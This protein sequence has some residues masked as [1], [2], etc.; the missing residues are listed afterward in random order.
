MTRGAYS[1]TPNFL[2]NVERV[3][4]LPQELHTSVGETPLI[5]LLL[6]SNSLT[7]GNGVLATDEGHFQSHVQT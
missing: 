5:S 2:A 4:A 7:A 6:S 3:A 1:V